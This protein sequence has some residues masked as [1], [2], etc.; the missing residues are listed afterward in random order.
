MENSA[1]S[2]DVYANKVFQIFFELFT[3]Q[4]YKF[5]SI[6]GIKV[7][8]F[9][10]SNNTLTGRQVLIPEHHY[11][12]SME[13][14]EIFELPMDRPG[15]ALQVNLDHIL[16]IAIPFAILFDESSDDLCTQVLSFFDKHIRHIKRRAL[17]FRVWFKFPSLLLCSFLCTMVYGSN[18]SRFLRR[19]SHTTFSDAYVFTIV[20]I[21]AIFVWGCKSFKR[22]KS[23]A[24]FKLSVSLLKPL[25]LFLGVFELNKCFFCW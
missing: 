14:W 18:I 15:L 17:Y 16:N 4:L 1:I 2:K 20:L 23:T 22:I 3:S 5:I 9:Q 19:W 13:L 21:I 25:N 11:Q 12:N 8:G 10:F 7:Y 6:R 24:I